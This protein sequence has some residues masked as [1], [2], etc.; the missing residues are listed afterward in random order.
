MKTVIICMLLFLAFAIISC[1]RPVQERH[2][3]AQEID[4]KLL[5]VFETGNI[6]SLESIIS[7]EF[8]NHSG[9]DIVGIDSLKKGVQEFHARF[10][11]KQME[12]K[13]QWAD[14]EYVADWVRYT[15]AKTNMVV[16]GIEVTRYA[17]GK[18]VEHWFFPKRQ[19]R[20]PTN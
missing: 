15:G 11:P 7:P 10:A 16:E 3:L 2:S 19:A 18:A 6:D 13:R 1:N 20:E 17:N 8:I 4:N 14:D 9:T 12:I 5:K